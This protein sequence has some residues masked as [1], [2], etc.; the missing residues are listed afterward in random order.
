MAQWFDSRQGLRIFFLYHRVQTGSVA[1][2]SSYPMG[3]GFFFPG[4]KRLG[5]EAKVSS[6]AST[7]VKKAWSYT[8]IPHT[9][10]W[11]CA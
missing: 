6:P 2:Q 9:S 8:S 11:R 7:E 5:R 3:T 10:S 4:L 1:H